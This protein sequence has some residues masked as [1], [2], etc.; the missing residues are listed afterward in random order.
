MVTIVPRG[1]ASK[2]LRIGRNIG[3]LVDLSAAMGVILRIPAA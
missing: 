3:Q 2:N 1:L